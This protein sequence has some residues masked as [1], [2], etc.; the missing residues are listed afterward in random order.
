MNRWVDSLREL[1][2]RGEPAM[3]VTVMDVRGS[4]PRECGAKMLVT[5]S[6]VIG[7][8]GGGQLEFECTRIACE[9][10][11][12]AR[13]A[14]SRSAPTPGSEGRDVCATISAWLHLWT[15]LRRC[16]GG[17]VRGTDRS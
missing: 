8:I 6:E 15:V 7:S 17:A 3:L 1:K 14:S 11:E 9:A 4:A 12:V 2:D 10:I 16:G 5:A 13:T